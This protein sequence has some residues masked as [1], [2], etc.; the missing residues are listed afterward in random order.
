MTDFTETTLKESI[1]ECCDRHGLSYNNLTPAEVS[2]GVWQ[3][4]AVEMDVDCS[5]RG[6]CRE[7]RYYAKEVDGKMVLC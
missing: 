7:M 2:P 6:Y 5:M 1:G 4:N 3:F